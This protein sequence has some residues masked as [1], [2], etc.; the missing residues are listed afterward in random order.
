[1]PHSHETDFH[2]PDEIRTLSPSKRTVADPHLRPRSHWGRFVAHTVKLI[3]PSGIATRLRSGR[4]GVRIPVWPWDFSF[5][6]NG[7]TGPGGHPAYYLVGPWFF[8]VRKSCW[9]AKLTTRLHLVSRWRV[10]GTVALLL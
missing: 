9:R 1:M 7:Q 6:Q 2:A 10:S 8:T 3:I 4:S 5:L